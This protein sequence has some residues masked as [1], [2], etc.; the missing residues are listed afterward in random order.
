MK[1]IL[2]ITQT[3]DGDKAGCGV[4]L[5]GDLLGRTLKTHPLYNFN[6]LYTDSD[7]EVN[8]HLASNFYYDAIIYNFHPGSTPWMANLQLRRTHPN[9]KHILLWH[10]SYQKVADT[11]DH[12]RDM[13]FE[14]LIMFDPTIRGNDYVF[15]T[16]RIL[17]P[18][19]TVTYQE[20]EK[21]RIGFHG[22]GAGHKGLV[23]LA[24]MVQDE[25]DEATLRLHIPAAYYGGP[26]WYNA[27]QRLQEVRQV[28]HKPGIEVVATFDMWDAQ[29]LVNMLA[30][31]TINCYLYDFLDGAGLSSSIDYALSARRPIASSRSHQMRNLWNLSPS[32]LVE[33]KS[34]KEII[35]QG[36]APLEQLYIDYSAESVLNDYTRILQHLIG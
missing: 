11:W 32:V 10:D 15:V 34:L 12:N 5:L 25:F 9:I 7:L 29:T 2:F 4:G 17:P 33:E 24:N 14:Y 28:L 30:Q 8:L 20:L 21:P 36:T 31:N 26:I 19:A 18:I 6:L 23:R 3:I 1:N 35:A 22:F 16:N 27:Q 13:N